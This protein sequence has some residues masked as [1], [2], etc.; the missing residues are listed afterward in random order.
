MA[1][2]FRKGALDKLSSP[3][4]LDRAVVLIPRSGWL[5]AAG[6]IG[7]IVVALIWSIVGRLPETVNVSGVYIADGSTYSVSVENGG[8]VEDIL[9]NKGDIIAEGDAIAVVK[10]DEIDR[11]INECNDR[12]EK[13]EAVTLDSQNDVITADNKNLIDIKNQ[14]LLV[15]QSLKQDYAMLA[16]RTGELAEQQIKTNQAESKTLNAE[17]EYYSSLNAGD[18]TGAQLAYADAQAELSTNSQYLENALSNLASARVALQSAKEQYDNVNKYKLQIDAAGSNLSAVIGASVLLSEEQKNQFLTLDAGIIS[19]ELAQADPFGGDTSVADAARAYIS[20][21]NAFTPEMASALQELTIQ[22]EA[23]QGT[24]KNLEADVSKYSDAKEKAQAKYNDAKNAYIA[25]TS[26]VLSNQ[27]NTS[28]KTN[29]Y[30]VAINDYN[31]QLSTL[32]GLKDSVDQLK[33]QVEIDKGNVESQTNNMYG[34]FYATK[35]ATLDQLR[36]ELSALNSQKEQLVLRSQIA[37]TVSEIDVSR[38][39]LVGAGTVVAKVSQSG[40][41]SNMVVCYVPV[42][43][44]KKIKEGMAVKVYPSTVNKQE[45]G[46]M[47]ATVESVSEYVATANELRTTLASDELMSLFTNNGALVAVKCRLKE[48]ENTA[49]GY[50][51]SSRKGADVVLSEGTVVTADAIVAQKAPISLVIP[52]IKEKL[53]GSKANTGAN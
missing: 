53:S 44:G 41:A 7:M 2:L 50:Y 45:Y 11:K 49:S 6:A 26:G 46:H 48:D 3:D 13:V 40:G 52:Y 4:Q 31:T 28:I 10:S 27:S 12:I 18:S 37:G 43:S 35:S 51:W 24:V 38:G 16:F 5:A 33:T 15:D 42:S 8:T 22:L 25:A 17:N 34:S 14:L 29:K 19:S 47:E 21:V 23:G 30:N 9:V 20:A 1:D 36:L 39:E 32:N